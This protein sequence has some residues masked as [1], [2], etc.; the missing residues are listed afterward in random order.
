MVFD[1][2]IEDERYSDLCVPLLGEHQARNCALA[3]AVCRHILPQWDIDLI[4]NNLARLE[5]PGRM[6][7][8]SQSPFI[9]LD[10]CIN[11]DS[12]DSIKSVLSHLGINK[13]IFIVGI[14][15]DKDFDG[16]VHSVQ[17][18]SEAVILTKSSNPH[19]R[20]SDRQYHQ[21]LEEGI[22]T[23]NSE[24]VEDALRIAEGYDCPIAILGTTSVIADVKRQMSG[25]ETK[26]LS[27]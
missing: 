8:V 25:I 4:R 5:W 15:D 20:F 22:R 10:A 14:P 23:I 7:I 11:R 17:D 2:V 3:M 24:S 12:T 13:C 16:V 26:Q 9:L 21:L 19:Y 27:D 18:L 6:E 1:V